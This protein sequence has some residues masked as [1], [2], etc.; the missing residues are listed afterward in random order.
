MLRTVSLTWTDLNDSES[1]Y[2]VERQDVGMPPGVPTPFMNVGNLPANSTSFINNVEAP[3]TYSWRIRAIRFD[4]FG[5]YSNVV[6]LTVS[7]PLVA[8]NDLTAVEVG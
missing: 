5:P 7:V 4:E 6:T 3:G 1:G 8:I 2:E